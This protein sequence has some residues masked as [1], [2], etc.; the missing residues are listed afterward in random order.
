MG[1]RRC[2]EEAWAAADSCLRPDPALGPGSEGRQRGQ[3][4]GFGWS[5]VPR[6]QHLTGLGLGRERGRGREAHGLLRVQGR[7]SERKGQNCPSLATSGT[8]CQCLAR[9][10]E[11]GEPCGQLGAVSGHVPEVCLR[12][13]STVPP[14]KAK[15]H[16]HAPNQKAK[17]PPE[18]VGERPHTQ[19]P[20]GCLGIDAS[21]RGVHALTLEN[22]QQRPL[23][24]DASGTG[25]T[26]ASFLLDLRSS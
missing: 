23:F 7:P 19:V 2:E 4:P 5:G 6:E 21:A 24:R 8:E 18:K 22:A 17:P 1:S 9:C 15:R 3:E 16:I 25:C 14:A 11:E 20:C 12:H 13:G 26:T 10:Q